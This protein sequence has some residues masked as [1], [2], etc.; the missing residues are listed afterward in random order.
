MKLTIE[1]KKL[2]ENGIFIIIMTIIIILFI[3]LVI[4]DL[5]RKHQIDGIKEKYNEITS[6]YEEIRETYI[7]EIGDGLNG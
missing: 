4:A 1:E 5:D 7:N 6:Q 3:K 2:I